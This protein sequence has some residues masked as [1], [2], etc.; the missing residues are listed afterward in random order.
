MIYMVLID[1][2]V[3]KSNA[4][5]TQCW[6]PDLKPE[7]PSRSW[8]KRQK[9]CDKMWLPL[10]ISSLF[11]P[12]RERWVRFDFGKFVIFSPRLTSRSESSAKYAKP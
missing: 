5:G 11:L 1:E 4:A 9:R 8:W 3:P 12:A 2:M 7:E 6:F 10:F